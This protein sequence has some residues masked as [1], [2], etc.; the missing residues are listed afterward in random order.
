MSSL[1]KKVISELKALM[2]ENLLEVFE[3]FIQSSNKLMEELV[4]EIKSGQNTNIE[5]AA[6][7]LKGSSANIGAKTLSEFSSVLVEMAR[8][9]IEEDFIHAMKQLSGEHRN[10]L[11]EINEFLNVK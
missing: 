4:L 11:Q 7:T 9:N 6:H 10:V 2:G 3:A 1:D 8:G 5:K